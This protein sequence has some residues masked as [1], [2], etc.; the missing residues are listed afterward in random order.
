MYRL[1]FCVRV[2]GLEPPSLAAP[3]PK[4][5][6]STNFTTPA[7]GTAKVVFFSAQIVL[8]KTIYNY[9]EH[10]PFYLVSSTIVMTIPFLML[11]FRSL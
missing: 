11:C 5:G 7:F 2:E 4:S 1:L 8:Q 6:V 10:N 9:R 3:D